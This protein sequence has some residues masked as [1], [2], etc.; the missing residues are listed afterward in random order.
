MNRTK[1]VVAKNPEALAEALGLGYRVEV[2]FSRL[3]TAA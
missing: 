1:P 2:S 3:E